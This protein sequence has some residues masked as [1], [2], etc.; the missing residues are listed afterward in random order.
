MKA[1]LPGCRTVL[2]GVHPTV[3]PGEVLAEESVDLVVRGEGERTMSELAS[4]ARPEEVDGVS[5]RSG[6]EV[7]HNAEREL[8]ADLDSLPFPAYHLLPMKLYHPAVGAY[9][10]LPASAMLATRGCPGRC[11]F[12]YR[13]F[14]NRLRVRSGRRV[15][16][17]AKLLQ[18][19]YGI[20]EICFYDDTFTVVKR[21]VRAFCDALDELGVDLTWSCFSRVDAVYE[22]M[23]RR[24]SSAGCH[25]VMYGIESASAE[26][27]ENINKRT[28]LARAE[29]AVRLSKKAGLD[30]RAAFMLGSPGET[31]E[32]MEES[33]AFAK[34]LN[35]E[36][37]IFNITTPYPGT[38]MHRWAAE[39]GYLRTTDWSEYDLSRPVMEL[40]T[41]SSAKV[42]E[43]YS[44][45]FRRFAMRP[46]Y[47]LLRFW[48]LRRPAD[49]YQALKGLRA[50]LRL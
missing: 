12:C 8:I 3:R 27:L 23:L 32:S 50:M 18:D 36:L 33:L 45:A 39:N 7:V 35:P 1:E 11:T 17:E 19:D 4:G 5:Y 48:K 41:V 25:Q 37:A 38:E 14:G 21:E 43:F 16:E 9:R 34:R 29:E 31:E 26:V 47:I 46:R 30:V 44:R 15:A 28:D 13:I 49:L 40:P 24:M 22:E 2:G 6:G 20:R 10:R 42:A